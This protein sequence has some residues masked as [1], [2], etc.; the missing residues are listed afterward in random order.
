MEHRA[1]DLSRQAAR[2][3]SGPGEEMMRA[4]GTFGIPLHAGLFCGLIWLLIFDTT[5]AKPETREQEKPWH[6]AFGVE[7]MAPGLG[8]IY[9][10]TGARW[11]KNA[12]NLFHWGGIEPKPPQD[13]KHTYD[14]AWPDMLI[15]EYQK[16]GFR[17]FQIYTQ[18]RNE[19]ATDRPKSII[20]EIRPGHGSYPVKPEHVKD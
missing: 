15:L 7:Y 13:G 16:A 20:R 1:E 2:E 14:W 12:P 4:A 11:A 5:A 10:A 3:H 6:F 19:W 9:A 17:N 8:E 18:A